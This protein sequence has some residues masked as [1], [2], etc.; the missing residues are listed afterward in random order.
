M[1]ISQSVYPFQSFDTLYKTMGSGH[2]SSQPVRLVPSASVFFPDIF[3]PAFETPSLALVMPT[4]PV[5]R[6]GNLWLPKETHAYLQ[7]RVE[8]QSPLSIA[9]NRSHVANKSFNH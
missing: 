2:S 7:K 5:V 1:S 8:S 3:Q 4:F 6:V 9:R